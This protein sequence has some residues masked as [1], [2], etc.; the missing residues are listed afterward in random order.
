MKKFEKLFA[1]KL[2]AQQTNVEETEVFSTLQIMQFNHDRFTEITS[3]IEEIAGRRVWNDF[4]FKLGNIMGLLRFMTFNR[5]CQEEML[6]ITKL[7]GEHLNMF[8]EAAGQLPYADPKT[9]TIIDGRPMK[10]EELKQLLLVVASTL[11]VV[12]EDFQLEDINEERWVALT[13]RAYIK[14]QEDIKANIEAQA[15]A[16]APMYEE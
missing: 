4:N 15:Q 1:S 12:V 10:Y 6:A 2:A 7:N 9:N 5:L 3:Q 14:A 16:E 8:Y 13:E 11:G